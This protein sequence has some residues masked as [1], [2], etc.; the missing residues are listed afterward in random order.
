MKKIAAYI[1]MP[2]LGDTL[3]AIPTINKLY[4]AHDTPITV[5]TYHPLLFKDRPSVLEALYVH[6][7]DHNLYDYFYTTPFKEKI[8]I[9][10]KDVEFKHSQIDIRQFHALSLGFSL[11]PKE[12]EIDLYIKEDWDIGFKDYV[13]IH[14]TYTWDSRTWD[15][16]KYQK[17]IDKLNNK[18]IPV[19][20][21]G[22]N[23]SETGFHNI[24]KPVM[25]IKIQYGINLLN[26]PE[27]SLPK[28]RSLIDKAKCLVVMDSGILH[29]GGTTDVEIIQLGSS[30]DPY[31]RAPYRKGS[32]KYKYTFIG[33][34]CD[35]FCTSNMKHHLKEWDTI[36][37][38]P[39]LVGC[40]ENKPSFEC[41]PDEDKVFNKILT[42]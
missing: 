35:L 14:P 29:L 7:S 10:G 12:M 16:K 33:G 38:V 1:D 37:G 5:F 25:D 18:G 9:N 22:K 17:L 34:G 31:F 30:I 36:Q 4:Q 26:H 24:S 39:P 27:G 41:H 23:S 13:I 20:A 6:Q 40:L 8:K 11:T 28:I 2:A 32:Q 19:V 21:I 42:L 3:A 15:T